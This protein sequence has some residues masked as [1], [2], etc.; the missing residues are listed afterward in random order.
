MIIGQNCG[1]SR[2]KSGKTWHYDCCSEVILGPSAKDLRQK[3]R[4]NCRKKVKLVDTKLPKRPGVEVHLVMDNYG[5]H[6]TPAVKR[7]L[8]RHPEYHVHFT[9]TS[10]SWLNQVERF[11]AEITEKMI[12]RGVFRSVEALVKAIMA[13]LEEHNRDPKP[14]VWTADAD[15]ILERVERICERTSVSGH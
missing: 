9:P 8:L 3:P 14:F 7:W 5:T 4:R 11:F 10:G 13:Y 1:F 15:L 12:R 2:G 6:K